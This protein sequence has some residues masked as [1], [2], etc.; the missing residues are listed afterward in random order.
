M[1]AVSPLLSTQISCAKSRK[2]FRFEI[3][4]QLIREV[5]SREPERGGKI[6]AV[7]VTAYARAEDRM[8]VLAAGFQT[9]ITKPN[10]PFA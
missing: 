4:F 6:P 7:A 5:R 1:L 10:G 3:T 9:H 8:R 2:S